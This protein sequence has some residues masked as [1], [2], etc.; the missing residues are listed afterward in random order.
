MEVV[1]A[2]VTLNEGYENT[3]E[4]VRELNKPLPHPPR[5]GRQRLV[6]SR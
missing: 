3:R 5:T 6:R 4:L 1:K 2:F